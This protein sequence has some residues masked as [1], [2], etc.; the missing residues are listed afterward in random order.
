MKKIGIIGGGQLGRMM[1]MESKNLDIFIS[2][3]DP[4]L[5]CPAAFYADEHILGS[6]S[7]KETVLAFGEGKDVITFEIE[8][9]NAEALFE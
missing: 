3:L 4:T 6:F 9:A 8:S 7:D 5:D 2:V 1:A